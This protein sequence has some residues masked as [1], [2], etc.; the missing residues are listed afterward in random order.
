MNRLAKTEDI[1]QMVELGMA[2]HHEST[3]RDRDFDADTL[4]ENL[5]NMIDNHHA[6]AVVS[7]ID[8]R[9]VGAFLG[10]IAQDWFGKDMVAF[11]YTLFVLPEYRQGTIA[12][13]M[14]NSFIKWAENKRVKKIQMGITTNIHPEQTARFYESFG[15]APKGQ[16]FE[17]EV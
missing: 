9:I 17:M 10:G 3:Y 8:N 4:S 12:F 15:F 5:K 1:P 13:R 7:E 6:F 14:I 16:M 2:L 11:D